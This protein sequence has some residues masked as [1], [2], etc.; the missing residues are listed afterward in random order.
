M[1]GNIKHTKEF[2]GNFRIIVCNLNNMALHERI[3]LILRMSQK[4]LSF[5]SLSHRISMT[6][7]INL[8]VFKSMKQL[9]IVSEAPK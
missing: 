9:H 3:N 5:S 6:E 7:A 1:G 8:L 2:H 4:D